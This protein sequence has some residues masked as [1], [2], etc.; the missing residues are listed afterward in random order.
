[1]NERKTP[2]QQFPDDVKDHV[3]TVLIDSDENRTLRFSRPDS[4]NDRFYITTW[5]GFLC[6]SG[7]RGTY[8]FERSPDMF[9]FFRGHGERG[10]SALYAAEKVVSEDRDR[11]FEYEPKQAEDYF[12]KNFPLLTVTPGYFDFEDERHV[13]DFLSTNDPDANELGFRKPTERFLWCL[14]AIAWAI[15]VYDESHQ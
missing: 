15:K 12:R 3:M 10:I 14:E 4:V 8:V 6:F 13:R 5:R 2:Q 9:R 11:V 1:M 7:D